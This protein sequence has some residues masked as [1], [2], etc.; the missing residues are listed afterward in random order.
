MV[1]RRETKRGAHEGRR[2]AKPA[3][4]VRPVACLAPSIISRPVSAPNWR[5]WCRCWRRAST[6]SVRPLGPAPEER[7]DPP[8]HPLRQLRAGRLG[9][10]P[11]GRYF[12]DYD[13]LAEL[14][15][16]ER[17]CTPV[18]FVVHTQAEVDDALT[19]RPLYHY[20]QH[21]GGRQ[22]LSWKAKGDCEVLPKS[23]SRTQ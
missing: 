2:V 22:R 21:G 6:R 17:L 16:G 5:S 9:G 1:I 14:S 3:V 20:G 13:L 10:S 23:C 11:S 19:R 4:A 8:H 12:S 15:S 18:N 7:P